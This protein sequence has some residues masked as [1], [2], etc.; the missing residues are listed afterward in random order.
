VSIYEFEISVSEKI[1]LYL[2]E[3]KMVNEQKSV[4]AIYT[5]QFFYIYEIFFLN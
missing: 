2:F 1:V 3:K 5:R 4:E